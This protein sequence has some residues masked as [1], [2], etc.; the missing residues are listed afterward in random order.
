MASPTHAVDGAVE[1]FRWWEG[2][3]A[4]IKIV[5]N[6]WRQ[7]L[8]DPDEA[9]AKGEYLVVIDFMVAAA[10]RSAQIDAGK[11]PLIVM[12]AKQAAKAPPGE[13][14]ASGREELQRARGAGAG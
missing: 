6:F 11:I 9:E 2:K 7:L 1:D 13:P 4:E 14:G 5:A 10:N 12:N 8:E 3:S